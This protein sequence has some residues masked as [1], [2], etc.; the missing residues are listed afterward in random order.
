MQL[1]FKFFSSIFLLCVIVVLARAQPSYSSLYVFGGA[2]PSTNGANP[3]SPV[4]FDS[5]GN[6]Y[7]TTTE[8]GANG[9]GGGVLWEITKSGTYI[10]LH[11][12]GGQIKSS[13]GTACQDGSIIDGGVV[14]DSAGNLY[15]TA[16]EGGAEGPQGAGMVWEYTNAGLYKDLH[17]FGGRILNASGASVPDGWEPCDAPTFDSS[18]NMYGTTSLGGANSS[19][20]GMVWEITSTGKYVDIHDFGG[21][22][23]HE[24][25]V[26]GPDGY[27]PY[28]SVT[29]DKSGNLYGTTYYGGANASGGGIIWEI[30]SGSPRVYKDLHD[31]GNMISDAEGATSVDGFN[32]HN[33]VTFDASGDIFCTAQLGGPNNQGVVCE[34]TAAH[35]YV[36]LHDFGT[37]E[38]GQQPLSSVSID[39]YGNLFGTTKSGGKNSA[40]MAWELPPTG[41]EIDLHDFGIYVATVAGV[42]YYDAY[43]PFSVALDNAGNVYG[44]AQNGGDISN[45]QGN[46]WAIVP[47]PLG[48]TV[49]GLNSSAGATAPKSVKIPYGAKTATFPISTLAVQTPTNPTI[50]ATLESNSVTCD[51]AVIGLESTS[52][53]ATAVT[54]GGTLEGTVMLTGPAPTGGV[55]VNLAVSSTYASLSAS[56]VTIAAGSTVSSQFQILTTPVSANT[57]V[58]VTATLGTVHTTANFSIVVPT[59]AN[60]YV[61]NN[62]IVGGTMGTGTV[63]LSGNV[64]AATTVSLSVTAVEGSVGSIQLP[65]SSTV[66]IMPGEST[67][68]FT[69]NTSGV[70]AYT[71]ETITAQLGSQSKASTFQIVGIGSITI[72]PNT[73]TGGQ[74]AE[75]Y[76]SPSGPIGS[77]DFIC[78]LSA[79]SAASPDPVTLP[80]T[81]AVGKG[82]GPSK[83]VTSPVTTNTI[84]EISAVLGGSMVT[85]KLLVLAPV[86]SSVTLST[87]SV[88][89]SSSTVVTGTVTLSGPVL[90]DTLVTLTSSETSAASVI[91]TLKI[92]AGSST[93]T[94][95]VTHYT[96]KSQANVAITATLNS[97]SQQVKIAITP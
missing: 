7:G 2:S 86:V 13:T 28:A 68:T 69:F 57:P 51:F 73:V 38:D 76:L 56:S 19:Q 55:T 21:V 67:A 87:N 30:T 8:G 58:T 92:S 16:N 91:S 10:D 95:T 63:T 44:T 36:D 17:D 93:G 26:S 70:N 6:M 65:A 35:G 4:T 33:S 90:A 25:G 53:S 46:A 3:T 66:T 75:I 39:S 89:G 47:A 62:P 18:G 23:T 42:E 59:L 52:V 77:L 9:S 14:F 24:N 61:A 43:E 32:P 37:G 40:G 54:G 64:A 85:G 71:V 96:V 20:D 27:Y 29:I 11:D 78:S 72:F 22:T 79:S 15:G 74:T 48:G 45:G 31:F 97:V 94:F 88:Q 82:A 80:S 60:F 83:V 50:T 1:T 81:A 41:A 49:I 5:N 84:V 34:L 12:F